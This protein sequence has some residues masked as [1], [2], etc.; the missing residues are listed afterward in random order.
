MRKREKVDLSLQLPLWPEE[1][2]QAQQENQSPELDLFIYSR[3]TMKFH[4]PHDDARRAKLR[5][6]AKQYGYKRFG[7]TSHERY[8][9]YYQHIV[10]ESEECWQNFLNRGVQFDIYCCYIEAVAPHPLSFY[11]EDAVTRGELPSWELDDKLL[12]KSA[13]YHNEARLAKWL[14]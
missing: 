4:G 11:L 5:E 3:E 1:Q 2:S 6:W 14:R 10:P 8:D 12:W 7:Y 9:G 13:D